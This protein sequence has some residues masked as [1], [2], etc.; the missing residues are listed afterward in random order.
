MFTLRQLL[1]VEKHSCLLDGHWPCKTF[2]ITT[3]TLERI[4][5]VVSFIRAKALY[6]SHVETMRAREIFRLFVITS[7]IALVLG[8]GMLID[9]ASRNS[10][11]RFFPNRPAQYTDNELNCGGFSVQWSKN[12][13]KCGVCGDAYHL[14]NPKYVYPGRYAKDRFVTK[15]YKEGQ[16][17][18]VS[19]KITSNHQ[20]FFRFSVGKLQKRPITQEQLKHILLQ[21]D[22]SN[23][24][25][26]HS[27]RNGVFKIKLVLP[28]GLTCDYCVIQWWW[29]VG[30]NWGCNDEG[31]CGEGLAKRQ[32]TFV[33][34]ADIRITPAGGPAP[35][36]EKPITRPPSTKEP[37]PDTPMM[38]VVGTTQRPATSAL[39]AKPST[40]R[41]KANGSFAGHPGMDSWCH[42]N[43]A[44]GNCPSSHC[45]CS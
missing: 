19:V 22:G 21:P 14:T 7:L 25:P 20:G 37:I 4:E 42:N 31:V 33:N 10:A 5:R 40:G 17:I 8:H 28:K 44:L 34:C 41:C 9:P 38:T 36:T 26:L 45:I 39:T 18:E 15:T 13:G 30:N 27:S 43:C 29:T 16:E 1:F 35:S 12:K 32:E 23:T 11:W 24:W 6:S 3:L 2:G